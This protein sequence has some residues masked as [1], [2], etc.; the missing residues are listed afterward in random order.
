MSTLADQPTRGPNC[1][2]CRHFAITHI[3]SSPYACRSMG[4]QSR[5]LPSLEVLRVDGQFC[6]LFSPKETPAKA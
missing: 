5:L 1:W 6:R 3:P 2:H 4:F